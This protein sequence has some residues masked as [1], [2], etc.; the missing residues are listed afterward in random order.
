MDG[1]AAVALRP[2]LE[3][4]RITGRRN[5]GAHFLL[6][7]NSRESNDSSGS[8]G[9]YDR[10]QLSQG[11]RG[12]IVVAH[13]MAVLRT[14]SGTLGSNSTG[15]IAQ[16][17]SFAYYGKLFRFAQTNTVMLVLTQN[18]RRVHQPQHYCFSLLEARMTTQAQVMFYSMHDRT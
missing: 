13:G 8:G 12:L 15:S 3:E 5:G 14:I 17:A 9:G 6:V 16:R 10:H 1:A 4:S 2:V 7:G 11:A 18:F